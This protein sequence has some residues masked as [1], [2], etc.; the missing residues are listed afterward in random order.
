MHY[1]TPQMRSICTTPPSG[2]LPRHQHINNTAIVNVTTFKTRCSFLSLLNQ[3]PTARNDICLYLEKKS[4]RKYT[5]PKNNCCIRRTVVAIT[6]M[7]YCTH[8]LRDIVRWA[9]MRI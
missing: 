9:H 2:E 8:L 4:R 6:L 7:Y 5:Q 3:T 1:L